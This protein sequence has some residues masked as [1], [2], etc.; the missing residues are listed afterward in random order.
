MKL[1]PFLFFVLTDSGVFF[2]T[3]FTAVSQWTLSSSHSI[4]ER[5]LI[6]SSM[7]TSLDIR[8]ATNFWR[9]KKRID[10]NKSAPQGSFTAYTNSKEQYDSWEW[11]FMK[12]W[13]NQSDQHAPILLASLAH[14]LRFV[15]TKIIEKSLSQ[16]TW[17][18]LK[19]I[20]MRKKFL[21]LWPITRFAH[22][23]MKF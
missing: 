7:L 23:A 3:S 8:A 5:R 10:K 2:K 15:L 9:K 20:E 22:S 6:E 14:V 17:N 11:Y 16:S 18:A 21:P 4:S 19:R 13:Y 1:N 12:L